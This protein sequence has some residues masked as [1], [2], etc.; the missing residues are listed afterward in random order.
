MFRKQIT[1]KWYDTFSDFSRNVIQNNPT[2][3]KNVD[4]I[5][6]VCVLD[7]DNYRTFNKSKCNTASTYILFVIFVSIRLN[8]I[9][10]TTNYRCFQMQN[11]DYILSHPR[12]LATY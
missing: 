8:R 1:P 12:L 10:I 4:K 7:I 9:S 2:I 3:G 6:D 11:N 5:M